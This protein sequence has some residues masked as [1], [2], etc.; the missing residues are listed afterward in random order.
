MGF[1]RAN[2]SG[3]KTVETRKFRRAGVVCA[4][5]VDRDIVGMEEFL[6]KLSEDLTWEQQVWAIS[7]K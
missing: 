1:V 7:M 4:K 2:Q 3:A 5:D 6:E